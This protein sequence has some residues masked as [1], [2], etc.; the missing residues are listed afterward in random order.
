[1]KK[2]FFIVFILLFTTIFNYCRL[3]ENN[4][5]LVPTQFVM[6][7]INNLYSLILGK[8]ATVWATGNNSSG[9]LGTGQ[10]GSGIKETT[11]T[12]VASDV[13]MIAAGG[14]HS[15]IIK[16]DGTVW[17]T[18]DNAYGQLGKVGTYTTF[19]PVAS[20]VKMIA[21]GYAHSLILKND[22][23]LW[24]TGSN[25]T[26]QLGTGDNADRNTFTKVAY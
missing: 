18:G 21:A 15:L 25:D 1:M 24:G 5:C 9:Q 10:S 20:D 7:K 8:D 2:T 3:P 11:F 19:T 23:T 26:G 13:K 12:K 6:A 17:A 14:S 22:G 16:T 4:V